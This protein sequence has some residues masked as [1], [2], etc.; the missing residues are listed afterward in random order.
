MGNC[1]RCGAELEPSE[2]CASCDRRPALRLRD[3]RLGLAL[4]AVGI[5][6]LM[7]AGYSGLTLVEAFRTAEDGGDQAYAAR[8]R[9][10]YAVAAF[11]LGVVAIVGG[12]RSLRD[13]RS[14]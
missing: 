7:Y 11:A 5:T 3:M 1:E 10:G 9:T 6:F 13:R 2:P 4:F 12:A 8:R 14:D